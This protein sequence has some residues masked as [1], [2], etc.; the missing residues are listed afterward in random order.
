MRASWIV[1]LGVALAGVAAAATPRLDVDQAVHDFG[2]A[3]EGML[4]TR[5]FTLRNVGTTVLNFTQQPS[6]VCPCTTIAPLATMS[7]L[8]GESVALRVRF[9]TTGFG[10]QKA[11][12]LVYVYSDDPRAA[13]RTLTIQGSV[14]PSLP[15]EGSAATLHYEFYL[16]VDLRAPDAFA[17]G[18]LLGAVNIPFAALSDWLAQLP[19]M[20]PIYLYDE[21]GAQA[22][23]AARMLRENGFFA[24]FAISG[25]LVGWWRDVGDLFFTWA[26]G[27]TRTPPTGTPVTG[28]FTLPATRIVRQGY[29]VILDLRPRDAYAGGRFPGSI[30][31]RPEEVPDFAAGIPRGA[32]LP[33]GYK[34]SIWCVDEDGSLALQTAQ[35]LHALGFS[36]AKA[37]VGGL[38]QW[39]LRYESELLWPETVR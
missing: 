6:T 8:P 12:S 35:Y 34:V 21:T 10:G 3:A 32:A 29:Q 23:Q 39:R 14:Q 9:D 33:D 7:L 17:Q 1:L 25:G 19:T 22:I 4:V 18:R 20:Y 28:A 26:V 5:D 37:L 31:L 16:L 38:P 13:Q 30:N 2:E 11:S 15:Y 27:A 24:A 36:H